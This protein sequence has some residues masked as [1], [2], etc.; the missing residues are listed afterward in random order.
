MRLH[1]FWQVFGFQRHVAVS[2]SRSVCM[3]LA[4]RLGTGVVGRRLGYFSMGRSGATGR[5][6]Q[7]A[8]RG[9]GAAGV[10]K[11]GA[12]AFGRRQGRDAG[13]DGIFGAGWD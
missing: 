13:C 5:L 3:T 1:V 10:G 9:A 4:R 8:E 6:Q 2:V 11:R 7:R 12:A